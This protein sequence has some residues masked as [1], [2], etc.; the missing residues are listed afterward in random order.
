[1]SSPV[2]A[3]ALLPLQKAVFAALTGDTQLAALVTGVF[4]QVPETQAYPY[5][6]LGDAVEVPVNAHDRH[7]SDTTSTLH[8]WSQYRGYS[9]ALTIAARIVQVLDHQPLTV[10]GHDH[11]ATRF[12][13]SQTLTDPEPPGD[14]RHVPMR[15]RT[16]TQVAPA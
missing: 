12:V 14:I 15:F 9:Q 6:V 1:M 3:S 11:I 10:E 13:S 2:P 16:S 4:D 7:G 8:V 5:V